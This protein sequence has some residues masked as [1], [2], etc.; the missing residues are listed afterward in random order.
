MPIL[1]A[2]VASPSVSSRQ[3]DELPESE[4]Q[5]STQSTVT[6][7]FGFVTGGLERLQTTEAGVLKQDT[8]SI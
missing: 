4:V 2:Q 3:T 7:L 5:R 8:A 1:W 6:L